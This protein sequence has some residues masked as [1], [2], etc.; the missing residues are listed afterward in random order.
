M[1]Q[2][3]VNS[4]ISFELWLAILM[5]VEQTNTSLSD[6]NISNNEKIKIN[7]YHKIMLEMPHVSSKSKNYSFMTMV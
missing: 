7:Q 3:K 5:T 4:P 1:K 2:T 6:L